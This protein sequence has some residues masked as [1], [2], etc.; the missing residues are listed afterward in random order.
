[1][2]FLQKSNK[3]AR[4]NFTAAMLPRDRKSQFFDCCRQRKDLIFKSA[5]VL[6]LFQ[7]PFL[8][9]KAIANLSYANMLATNVDAATTAVFLQIVSLMQIPCYAIMGLGFAAISRV[10]RQLAFSEP[11]F[12]GYHLKMGL[13]QNG[14]RFASIFLLGGIILHLCNLSRFFWSGFVAYVPMLMFA[15]IFLPVGLYML[16]QAVF[17]EVRFSKSFSNGIA[18]LAVKLLPTLGFSLLIMSLG[19][20]DYIPL[21]VIRILLN[22]GVILVSPIIGLGWLIFS[23]YVFDKTINPKLN[24]EI[25]GKGLYHPESD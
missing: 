12:F 25:I 2:G 24:L 22:G 6:L 21:L 8:A 5:L 15:A 4:H 3:S 7:L 19:L 13:S 16:S 17:Y 18:L 11:V 20:I 14:K 9:V 23:C 10:F 1:M